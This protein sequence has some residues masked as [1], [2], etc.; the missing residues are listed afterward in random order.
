[1]SDILYFVSLLIPVAAFYV[2]DILS[3]LYVWELVELVFC[4]LH[5]ILHNILFKIW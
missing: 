5:N 2:Y 1:M 4:I 3:A